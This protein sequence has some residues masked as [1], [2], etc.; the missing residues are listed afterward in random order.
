MESVT[1]SKTE[2]EELLKYKYIMNIVEEELHERPMKENFIKKTE[3][4]RKE[5]EKGK[6][7]SFSSV[8]EMDRAIKESG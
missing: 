4:L 8:D 1:I 7:V 3:E 5:M 6:K 2:Y